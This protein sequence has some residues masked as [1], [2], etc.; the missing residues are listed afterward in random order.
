MRKYLYQRWTRRKKIQSVPLSIEV[1]DGY[2]KTVFNNGKDKSETVL[3]ESAK[4]AH[5]NN[6][7][8]I[9]V[10]TNNY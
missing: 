9:S 6:L 5:D 3:K 1:L 7:I 2:N 4:Y 10:K 8:C